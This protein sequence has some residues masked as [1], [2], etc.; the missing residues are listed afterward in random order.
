[1]FYNRNNMYWRMGLVSI[2]DL[3]ERHEMAENE[4][5]GAELKSRGALRIHT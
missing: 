1:M 3:A 2:L 4:D 5:L